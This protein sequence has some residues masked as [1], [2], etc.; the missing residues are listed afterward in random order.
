[1]QQPLSSSHICC[2]TSGI[3]AGLQ[4]V[5]HTLNTAD[6]PP[7][8]SQKSSPQ[9]YHPNCACASDLMKQ[10]LCTV[11]GRS[12]FLWMSLDSQGFY[13][14]NAAGPCLH[15]ALD[16]HAI[17]VYASKQ[18]SCPL[19]KSSFWLPLCDLSETRRATCTHCEVLSAS[20]SSQSEYIDQEAYWAIGW[21][22]D[23]NRSISYQFTGKY[24]DSHV[25][26]FPFWPWLY[27]HDTLLN[28]TTIFPRHKLQITFA[29]IIINKGCMRCLVNKSI[30]NLRW[31]I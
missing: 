13:V 10:H 20:S 23:Q 11:H 1:M 9:L 27:C 14:M 7:M 31:N 24:C 3:C 30:I 22:C 18:R 28:R 5:I 25:K 21:P 17:G 6:K 15:A 29:T 2:T 12:L 8:N 4:P 16:M 19:H 26:I